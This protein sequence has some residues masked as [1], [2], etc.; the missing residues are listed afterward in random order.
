[1]YKYPCIKKKKTTQKQTPKS[2]KKKITVTHISH[3]LELII[4]Y[5]LTFVSS[6]FFMTVQFKI[7]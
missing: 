2:T 6:V 3:H 5:I 1:M 7:P 4:I